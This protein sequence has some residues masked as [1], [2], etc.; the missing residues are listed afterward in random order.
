ML[1]Q[2][3]ARAVHTTRDVYTDYNLRHRL[4]N[5]TTDEGTFRGV[6]WFQA[7]HLAHLTALDEE[8]LNL[9][10]EVGGLATAI[11]QQYSAVNNSFLVLPLMIDASDTHDTPK[12][13]PN[14]QG[15]GLGNAALG[16]QALDASQ[17]GTIIAHSILQRHVEAEQAPISS[18][19]VKLMERWSNSAVSWVQGLSPGVP[20]SA[21]S[22]AL[23]NSTQPMGSIC[24]AR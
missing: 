5:L 13:P 17:L 7:L 1:R 2:L 22:W 11:A 23:L 21:T 20:C 19:L 3:R 24:A 4:H 18:R 15:Q 9:E 14:P 16:M 6:P 12:F 8:D 10:T